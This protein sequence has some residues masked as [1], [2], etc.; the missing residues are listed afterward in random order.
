MKLNNDELVEKISKAF[1]KYFISK[2]FVLKAS[3]ASDAI[4][5]QLKKGLIKQEK[6][7]KDKKIKKPI[8]LIYDCKSLKRKDFC[9]NG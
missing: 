9:Y 7:Q 6:S 5:S 3:N 4:S 8:D 1:E 2:D